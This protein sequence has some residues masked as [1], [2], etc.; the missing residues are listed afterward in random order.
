[1]LLIPHIILFI[2][3][4]NT[5][6]IVLSMF[7]TVI[8]LT[9]IWLNYILLM[10]KGEY[11]L[12]FGSAVKYRIAGFLCEDFNIASSTLRN[13]KIRIGFVKCGDLLLALF[14]FFF[15]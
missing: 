13:I 11:I 10:S 14:N 9:G 2:I 1:M 12:S 7:F 4:P 6:H 8:I 5:Y 15:T 3:S